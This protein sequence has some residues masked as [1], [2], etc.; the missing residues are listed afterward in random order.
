MSDSFNIND[1]PWK[2]AF[3]AVESVIHY[4]YQVSQCR[5]IYLCTEADNTN[6]GKKNSANENSRRS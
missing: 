5:K 3:T 4:K 1:A 2:R 6:W